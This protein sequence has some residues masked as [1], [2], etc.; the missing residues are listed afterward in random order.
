MLKSKQTRVVYRDNQQMYTT[1]LC[2]L[3]LSECVILLLLFTDTAKL[4]FK[5][6][7][8]DVLYMCADYSYNI[9]LLFLALSS[10]LHFQQLFF[11]LVI[12]TVG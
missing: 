7:C 8:R 5:I 1:S 6:K 11:I 9:L 3:I 12:F 4:V 2:L 10:L